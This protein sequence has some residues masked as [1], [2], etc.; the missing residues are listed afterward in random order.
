[1]KESKQPA[2][3]DSAAQ[4]TRD[5]VK[6]VADA[7]LPCEVEISTDGVTREV[8]PPPVSMQYDFIQ[9][10]PVATDSPVTTDSPIT[11]TGSEPV[12]NAEE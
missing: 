8:S 1:M 2:A 11:T 5:E 9:N 3:C 7:Q 12:K 4:L 10:S 6:T